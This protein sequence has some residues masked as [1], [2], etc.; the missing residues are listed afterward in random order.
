MSIFSFFKKVNGQVVDAVAALV[1]APMVGEIGVV[2]HTFAAAFAYDAKQ[3]GAA[4]KQL[5][6]DDVLAAW[7]AIKTT[8]ASAAADPA[9]QK[10]LF[11]GNVSAIVAD[12]STDA[13]K[14]L[15][16]ALKVIGKNTLTTFS[17]LAL[18]MVKTG[19]VQALAAASANPTS[20]PASS[21]AASPSASG[22]AST[23]SK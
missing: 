9:L 20:Q 11:A 23:P 6:S 5:A 7:T 2:A 19:A 3:L 21:P 10:D 18:T 17:S 14:S 1:P 15:V 8:A 13:A 22:T 16:P 4:G 12:L